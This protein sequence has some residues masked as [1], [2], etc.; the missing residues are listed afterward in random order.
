MQVITKLCT[1]HLRIFVENYGVKL[2]ASHAHELVAAFFGY[3]SRA[4]MLADTLYPITNLPRAN[5]IVLTPTAPIDQRRK[6][7]QDLP[8]DLPDT[9]SLGEVIYT[10]LIAEKLLVNTPWSTYEQLAT[11]LADEYLRQNQMDKVYRAPLREGVKVENVHDGIH[12]TVLRQYQVLTIN[13]LL[14]ASIPL[15]NI[16]TTIQLKRIAGYIGYA[17][18]EISFKM[19]PFK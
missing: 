6:T 8:L 7:L 1:D 5:I 10:V 12:L 16:S 19:Q 4:A 2:K 18:P 13:M 9:Y 14:Q 11:F 17:K 3:K 15:V